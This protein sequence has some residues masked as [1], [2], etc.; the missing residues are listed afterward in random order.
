MPSWND[1]PNSLSF[2]WELNITSDSLTNAGV[3]KK[4]K[5]LGGKMIYLNAELKGTSSEELVFYHFPVAN[6]VHI[7]RYTF[8]TR[9]RKIVTDIFYMGSLVNG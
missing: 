7:F 8:S 4:L 3:R 1:I 5:D 6:K 2:G 9:G